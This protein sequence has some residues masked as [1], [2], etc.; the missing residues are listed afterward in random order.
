MPQALHIRGAWS[1][2]LT[3]VVAGWMVIAAFASRHPPQH[4][5]RTWAAGTLIFSLAAAALRW[6]ALRWAGAA[7]ALWLAALNAGSTAELTAGLAVVALALVPG[8]ST[9]PAALERPL[10]A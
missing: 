7:V 3:L 9:R 5:L 4:Q 8:P 10:R 6:P 2:A 1:R